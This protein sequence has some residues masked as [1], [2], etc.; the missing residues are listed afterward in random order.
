MTTAIPEVDAD[1]PRTNVPP[2]FQVDTKALAAALAAIG[3]V[4]PTRTKYPVLR[5][6]QIESSA[7]GVIVRATDMD[8]W[9]TVPVSGGEWGDRKVR[10]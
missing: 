2:S 9:V 3:D 6:V 1:I 7:Q 5:A 4:V 8:L 10:H